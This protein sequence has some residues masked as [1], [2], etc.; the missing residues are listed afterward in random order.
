MENNH[1]FFFCVT[2]THAPYLPPA[3]YERM[4]YHGDECK[5][6]NQSMEPIFNFEPHGEFHKKVGCPQGL[7]IRTTLYH[8]TMVR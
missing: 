6:G 4:F 5:P 8:S 2:W 7:Q 3:P 1:I